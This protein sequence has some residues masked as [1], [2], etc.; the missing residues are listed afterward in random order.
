MIKIY[1]LGFLWVLPLVGIW[2]Q[3]ADANVLYEQATVAFSARQFEKTIQLGEAF[4][5]KHEARDS[6]TLKVY[7]LL[8]KSQEFLGQRADLFSLT[9]KMKTAAQ[10]CDYQEEGFQVW[11]AYLKGV[12]AAFGGSRQ[13]A[14]TL[15]REALDKVA[16][17]D[18]DFADGVLPLIHNDLGYQLLEDNQPEGALE[19][20]EK[21][22]EYWK[23]NPGVHPKRNE[24]AILGNFARV[25]RDLFQPDRSM[26]YSREAIRKSQQFF[27]I[28]SK[29]AVE[30]AANHALLLVQLNDLTE[31]AAT[32]QRIEPYLNRLDVGTKTTILSNWGLLYREQ[33]NFEKA[34][35]KIKAAAAIEKT[36]PFKKDPKY[37]GTLINIA[38]LYF[39][40]GRTDEVLPVLYEADSLANLYGSIHHPTLIGAIGLTFSR[41]D[42]PKDALD[43]IQEA[44][45]SATRTPELVMMSGLPNPPL[46]NFVVAANSPHLDYLRFKTMA[47]W[48]I[49]AKEPKVEYLRVAFDTYALLHDLL[50]KT[51]VYADIWQDNKLQTTLQQAMEGLLKT[52]YA[53]QKAGEDGRLN[54]VYTYLQQSKGLSIRMNLKMNPMHSADKGSP[55]DSLRKAAIR[56]EQ[57]L[58]LAHRNPD[59]TS[60]DSLE[61]NLWRLY[62]ELESKQGGLSAGFLEVP[63]LSILQKDI[64]ETALLLETYLAPNGVYTMAISDR[65]L[66]LFFGESQE[67]IDSTILRVHRSLSDWSYV[68]TQPQRTKTELGAASYY[69]YQLLLEAVL[70]KYSDV[71]KLI[72]APNSVLAALPYEVLIREAASADLPYRDWAFLVKDYK[73]SYAY[74]ASVW[75]YQHRK[76]TRHN[77][78]Y[79]AAFAPD[80][81]SNGHYQQDSVITALQQSQQWELPFAKQEADRVSKLLGGDLYEGRSATKKSFWEKANQYR[82]MHLAMH[83]IAE[84]EA[85]EF[86]RLLFTFDSS[87]ATSVLYANELY[88]QR[89]N[90]DLVVLSACNT[91]W[92]GSVQSEGILSLGHAFSSAGVSATVMT[93]WPVADAAGVRLVTDFYENLQTGKSKS[94]ALRQAKKAFLENASSDLEGHPY[95]WAA[96]QLYGNDTPIPKNK[97]PWYSWVLIF[98]VCAAVV[99]LARWFLRDSKSVQ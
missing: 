26:P 65:E 14:I 19:H 28:G 7:L 46:D 60:V 32:Y 82:V 54:E 38:G 99:F 47:L 64:D 88:D 74:S 4:L 21:A 97:F 69:L 39:R 22:S 13:Q 56:S 58:F 25:Y 45:A 10:A 9:E 85:S 15:F 70:E 83:A 75:L 89:L 11:L 1:W 80:Y 51:F 68:N 2:G 92:G 5:R 50:Q 96:Y 29:E 95:F 78:K 52:S 81:V 93:L 24:V 31:A 36:I 71:E 23:I 90:A 73:I 34:L 63:D 76:K 35:E 94:Q 67:N 61:Q 48:N 33:G 41:L 84:Q 91:G 18:A 20:L 59:A 3:S 49:Y 55:L 8:A 72:V 79:M 77:W 62:D 87:E 37:I 16:V 66:R 43:Y 53:L 6:S 30:A 27:G 12:A 86:S 40:T 17:E 98:V 57:E 44:L 42:R